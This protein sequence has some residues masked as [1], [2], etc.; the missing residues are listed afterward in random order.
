MLMRL[1]LALAL[2]ASL[3][4]A[5]PAIAGPIANYPA[6][7]ALTGP[8]K[9]TITQAGK[10]V[11]ATA[12]QIR[13]YIAAPPVTAGFLPTCSGKFAVTND[14]LQSNS[15]GTT[16]WAL[17]GAT[18]AAPTITS[19]T[20]VAPDG[21]ATATALSI[22]TVSAANAYSVLAQ[23]VT[24][25]SA[26]FAFTNQIWAKNTT[27][28][29]GTAYLALS[30]GS[31]QPYVRAAIPG[32]GLWH[33]LSI[34]FP[35]TAYAN[36]PFIEI[37][38]D[39]RDGGEIASTGTMVVDIWHAQGTAGAGIQTY[40]ATTSAVASITETRNC[41]A[42][43]YFRDFTTLARYTGNPIT[44]PNASQPWR[45]AGVSTPRAGPNSLVGSTYYGLMASTD[46]VGGNDWF[47]FGLMQGANPLNWAEATGVPNP[48]ILAPG[49]DNVAHTAGTG[50]YLKSYL[51]HPEYAPSGCMVSGV[52]YRYCVYFSG[53]SAAAG[54]G[55]AAIFL[56]YSNTITGPYTLYSVAGVVTPVIGSAAF[57]SAGTPSLPSIV[58]DNTGK[59]VLYTSVHGNG[60]NYTMMFNSSAA[61]GVTWTTAG[62]AILPPISG[63]WDF[64][65]FY[66]YIDSF[67][68]K[69][70]CG[71]YEYFYT[72]EKSATTNGVYQQIGYAVSASPYGPWYKYSAP[73]F[74]PGSTIYDGT[75]YLGD[76]SVIF[77]DGLL[78]WLGDTSNGTT[79][80]H[81]VAATMSD[82][83]VAQ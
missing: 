8:E 61:D 39:L 35:D 64:S 1:R 79:A 56:A 46:S 48:V 76:T 16:P 11:N 15:F 53:N 29:N 73:V 71:F 21:T 67:V 4:L 36:T 55:N 28:S 41:P 78:Y 7:S 49:A 69:N 2:L 70:R 40:V 5:V 72:V 82:A 20:A 44:S 58:Q 3:V 27:P 12:S 9:F 51:L 24:N 31:G 66:G 68:I 47:G 25:E 43:V 19:T 57:A 80:A 33:Q 74:A 81:G 34:F 30:A 77:A 75:A 52:F 60:G 42:G 26:G 18:S 65:N 6:A 37:G 17:A 54:G 62:L 45:S 10:T 63:D 23:S 50:T 22:P 38:V 14:I 59:Y 83:C 32:D 13:N